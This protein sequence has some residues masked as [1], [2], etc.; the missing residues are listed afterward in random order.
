[1]EKTNGEKR[2]F[3]T[4]ALTEYGTLS[5]LTQSHK[6]KHGGHGHGWAWGHY[7]D[8]DRGFDSIFPVTS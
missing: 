2:P 1:M 8:H 6:A 3:E 4:P 5:E 7:K